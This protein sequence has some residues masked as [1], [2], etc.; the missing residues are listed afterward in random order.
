MLRKSKEKKIE[1]EYKM[2]L[3][4]SKEKKIVPTFSIRIFLLVIVAVAAGT[5]MYFTRIDS[6]SLMPGIGIN[7]GNADLP[8]TTIDASNVM[9]PIVDDGSKKWCDTVAKAR[10]DL[11][12]S[13][14]ITY[15]CEEMTPGAISAVVCMLTGAVEANRANKILFTARE[16]IDGAMA[17]GVT[18][19]ENIDKSM[20]HQLLLLREGFE[21]AP[22]DLASL[23]SVG[24][25]IGTAPNFELLDEYIPTY[26]RYKTT[27]TK[28]TVIGMSEYKC[29]L[30]MDA[31]TLVVGDI[32]SFMTC[33][34]FQKP[35]HRVAGTLDLDRGK[36]WGMNTGCILW[37]TSSKEM[38]RVFQLSRN[39][40]FMRRFSSDQDFL[41]HV[42]PERF[43]RE[44][45][46]KMILGNLV[47][48]D[49]TAGA[50][51]DLTWDYNAQ[52]HVEGEMVE[53]W[54]NHR[55]SVKILH[56]TRKKGWQC[57]E[58]HGPP[59]PLDQMPKTC[60]LEKG[61]LRGG[62]QAPICYCREAHLYWNALSKARNL[63]SEKLIDANTK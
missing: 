54:E 4:K 36:W 38:E 57:E 15:P 49:D 11:D 58:R 26:E 12:P 50:V 52:T 6:A 60:H 46:N 55:P 22:D 27:Y 48:E 18:I 44:R 56:F 43:N 9:N 51:V 30:L 5:F 37:R 7:P 42:Y 20:T 21:L 31:D 10:S 34:K 63:A 19:M 8:Q 24:W 62:S 29:A 2:Q 40:T 61:G 25:T 3:R 47:E 35:Q 17:L 39:D 41:N 16:Y 32:R 23:Q 45:N 13:L 53:F 59:P 33:D 14:A 28:V 1:R